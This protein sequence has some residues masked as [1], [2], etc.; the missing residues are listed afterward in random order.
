M[1]LQEI[2]L[3]VSVPF[4]N[5]ELQRILVALRYAVPQRARL[6]RDG[7]RKGQSIQSKSL[8]FSTH[9]N[10]SMVLIQTLTSSFVTPSAQ[11]LK[12]LRKVVA[13]SWSAKVSCTTSSH[14]F[15]AAARGGSALKI[16]ARP[17]ATT[18]PSAISAAS[19]PSNEGICPESKAV[20]SEQSSRSF[21]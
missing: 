4:K 6:G 13:D 14:P 2:G 1:C 11:G 17:V 18:A 8:S 16:A 20:V 5:H 7:K 10:G 9:T 21:F 3:L 12:S 15:G 19:R